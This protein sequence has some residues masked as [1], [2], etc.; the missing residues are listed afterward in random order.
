[1]HL[2][3]LL[4]I[5]QFLNSHLCL[6]ISF[7]PGANRGGHGLDVQMILSPESQCSR[8]KAE[9]QNP[10]RQSQKAAH[11]PAIIPYYWDPTACMWSWSQLCEVPTAPRS[12]EVAAFSSI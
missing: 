3:D 1:M 9:E 5:L 6:F 4:F 12:E 7:F 8:L 11:T 10:S 2:E